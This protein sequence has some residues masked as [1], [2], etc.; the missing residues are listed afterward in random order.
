MAASGQNV[1]YSPNPRLKIQINERHVLHYERLHASGVA[2]RVRFI[3]GGGGGFLLREGGGGGGA[4]LDPR[5]ARVDT[6][7]ALGCRDLTLP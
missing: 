7:V 3:G 5:E 6:L 4:F 1:P 2:S